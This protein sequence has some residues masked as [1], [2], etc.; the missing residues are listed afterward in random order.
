MSTIATRVPLIEWSPAA[1]S[2][3][4]PVT[5]TAFVKVK[6]DSLGIRFL[7]TRHSPAKVLQTGLLGTPAEKCHGNQAA[8]DVSGR[9]LRSGFR[10]KYREIRAYL[11]FFAIN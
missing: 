9:S 7:I 6:S 11:A 2:K 8:E 1:D 10:S 3:P 5:S 4:S